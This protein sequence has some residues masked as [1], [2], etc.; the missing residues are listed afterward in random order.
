MIS[1]GTDRRSDSAR[2]LAEP[3]EQV[4]GLFRCESIG[5]DLPELAETWIRQRTNNRCPFIYS[6]ER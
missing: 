4:E 6:Q 3:P 2:Q 1:G 5:I